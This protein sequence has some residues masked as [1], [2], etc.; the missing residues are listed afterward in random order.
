MPCPF[1]HGR[2]S[3]HKKLTGNPGAVFLSDSKPETFALEK[4]FG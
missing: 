4:V 3:H 1:S 2:I